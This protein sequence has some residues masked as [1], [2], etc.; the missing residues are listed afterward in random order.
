MPIFIAALLGGLIQAAGSIAGRVLLSIGVGFVT[1]TGVTASLD[2]LKG[3]I[4]SNINSTSSLVIAA[5]GLLQVDTITGIFIAAAT[6]KLM[7]AGLT[8][9]TLKKMV[10]K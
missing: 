10:F 6:V 1:Y 9:G 8:S 7:M 5:L 4:Q 3:I 2:Y